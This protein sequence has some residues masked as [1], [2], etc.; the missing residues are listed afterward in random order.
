MKK[1]DLQ[2][3]NTDKEKIYPRR[4]E[5][6]HRSLKHECIVSYKC[7]FF[8]RPHLCIVLELCRGGNLRQYIERTPHVK[9]QR[10]CS[11]AKQLCDGLEVREVCTAM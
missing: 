6:L 7:S 3:L 1:I 10:F 5:E 9:I 2:K 11:F 8:D 4:E